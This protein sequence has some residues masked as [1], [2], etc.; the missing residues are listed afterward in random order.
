MATH[1][2]EILTFEGCPHGDPAFE[3]AQRVVRETGTE[4]E[5]RRVDVPNAEAAVAQRFLGSPTI[6]IDGRDVEPGA[7]ERF[8]YA[9]SCRMYRTS[10]GLAGQPNE[11]WLRDALKCG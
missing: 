8:G 2:I 11:Q 7:D 1:L 9:I 3:L 4:A 5:V 6:R 10:V